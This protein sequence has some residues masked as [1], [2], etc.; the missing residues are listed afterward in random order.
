MSD[1]YSCPM[2][3]CSSLGSARGLQTMDTIKNRFSTVFPRTEVRLGR[4]SLARLQL[5]VSIVHV[6]LSTS[7]E[8]S[9]SGFSNSNDDA[10]C[11]GVVFLSCSAPRPPRAVAGIPQVRLLSWEQRRAVLPSADLC[12][13]WPNFCILRGRNLRSSLGRKG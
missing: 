12:S 7:D 9:Q 5:T 6:H 1:A 10:I 3:S 11:G 13:C 2:L 4:I 8:T